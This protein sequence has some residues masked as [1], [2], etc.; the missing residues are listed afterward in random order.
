VYLAR[1][2]LIRNTEQTLGALF[3]NNEKC[4]DVSNK[5]AS[6]T[7]KGWKWYML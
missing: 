7:V 5:K 6:Q 1:G 4:F 3:L 2:R